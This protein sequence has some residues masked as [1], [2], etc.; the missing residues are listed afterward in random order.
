MLEHGATSSPL[1]QLVDG[2][3]LDRPEP[4]FSGQAASVPLEVMSYADDD[5]FRERRRPLAAAIDNI[6]YR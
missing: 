5:R 4:R 2:E 6:F 1:I 3:H